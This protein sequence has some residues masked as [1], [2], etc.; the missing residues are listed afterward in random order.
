M[1]KQTRMI[2]CAALVQ[3]ALA[4]AKYALAKAS[5]SMALA[6]DATHT[7]CDLFPT[8]AILV[9]LL[10]SESRMRRFPRGLHKIENLVSLLISFVVLY[11]GYEIASEAILEKRLRSEI[12]NLDQVLVHYAPA[13]KKMNAA[14][15]VPVATRSAGALT[16][17]SLRPI[18][19]DRS[20]QREERYACGNAR[21]ELPCL[22]GPGRGRRRDFGWP[23][24]PPWG[25]WNRQ[26]RWPANPSG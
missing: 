18:V 4:A 9:C 21:A 23:C 22:R 20:V 13:N 6:A 14:S 17:T 11:A 5:G 15:A 7:L 12:P 2:I 19:S 26:R 1:N 10:L 3:R 16:V 25:V 8:L 24:G